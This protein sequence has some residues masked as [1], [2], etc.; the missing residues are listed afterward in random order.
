MRDTMLATGLIALAAC[1]EPAG[2]QEL[3]RRIESGPDGLAALQYA[4]RGDV[5][6]NATSLRI[7]LVNQFGESRWIWNRNDGWTGEPCVHAPVRAL[8]T[9]TGG[10]ISA[11]RVSLATAPIPAGAADLGTAPAEQAARFFL[12]LAA[13]MDGR[14]GR[15][16]LLAAVLADSTDLGRGLLDLSTNASLSRGLRESA[17]GWLGRE[18]ASGYASGTAFIQALAGLA[19]DPDA[20]QSVRTRAAGALAYAGGPATATLTA[21]ARDDD[22][23][24][25]KAAMAALARSADPKAR[26]AIREA[27]G[28]ASLAEPLRA[29]AIKA[30]GNRDATPADVAALR[31]LWP[32]LSSDQTRYAVLD[33]VGETGGAPNARWILDI[34][35]D[36]EAN[37]S[38]RARAVRAAE[39]AGVATAELIRLYDE[40]PDRR[41]KEAILEA[42]SRIG[43]RA[44]RRK[45]E[46]IASADTDP[47]MRK[48]ALRRLAQQGGEDARAA[49]E[50]VIARPD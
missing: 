42:L 7:G 20:P 43:D 37:P 40:G 33:L 15:D 46:S 47:T 30:L 5:C 36:P 32:S 4:A 38:H 16:A 34:A 8:L 26:E 45:I 14:L 6:G 19:R 21:L 41:V 39:R 48:S 18:L 25:A 49:L 29:E 22:A 10:Q 24:I 17:A 9:R 28:D 44:A 27:A 12:D 3:R 1:L 11:V 35:R 50:A 13:R 2:A 23:A 31:A